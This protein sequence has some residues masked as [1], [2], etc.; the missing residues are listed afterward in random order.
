[1]FRRQFLKLLGLAPLAWAAVAKAPPAAP[2][3]RGLDPN[4]IVY[5]RGLVV[6]GPSGT[7]LVERS[8]GCSVYDANG[9]ERIRW[10][11]W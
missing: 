5:G 1:M 4:R 9:V 2:P 11:V 8:D 3:D 10:G 7:Y 6:S